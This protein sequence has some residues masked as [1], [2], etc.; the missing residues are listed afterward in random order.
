LQTIKRVVQ[1]AIHTI[2][3]IVL[4]G[5]IGGA[6]VLLHIFTHWIENTGI[7]P[8]IISILKTAEI[9][10]FVVDF[11]CFSVFILKETVTLI[12]AIVNSDKETESHGHAQ[13]A[14]RKRI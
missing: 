4:F 1:F 14:P 11:V 5:I 13:D 7:S 9:A 10:I 3:G 12:K 8:Y 2:V 6:A